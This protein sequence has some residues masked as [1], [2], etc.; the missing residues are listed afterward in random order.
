MT[1]FFTV[2]LSASVTAS[3]VPVFP[4]ELVLVITGSEE[5]PDEVGTVVGRVVMTGKAGRGHRSGGVGLTCSTFVHGATPG[6][7]AALPPA[8]VCPACSTMPP[9]RGGTLVGTATMMIVSPG[10]DAACTW[11]RLLNGEVT[12][13]STLA[14]A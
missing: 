8:S 7:P 13:P 3:P 4:V 5:R 11:A 6:T 14:G 9:S 12:P 10:L 1:R 2:V